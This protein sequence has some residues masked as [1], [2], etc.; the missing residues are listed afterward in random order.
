MK[1]KESNGSGARKTGARKPPS[2][3]LGGA[4]RRR[5]PVHSRP[6]SQT[7]SLTSPYTFPNIGELLAF[8]FCNS[9]AAIRGENE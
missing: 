8:A 2:A 9:A 3:A 7:N 6:P 5:A 1:N 4:E